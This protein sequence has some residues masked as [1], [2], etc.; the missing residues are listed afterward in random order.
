MTEGGTFTSGVIQ[1]KEMKGAGLSIKNIYLHH[2]DQVCRHQAR[3]P[4]SPQREWA[5]G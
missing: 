1:K 3:L 5:G 4:S 2:N